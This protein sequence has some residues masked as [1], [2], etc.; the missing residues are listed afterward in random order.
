MQT[1]RSNKTAGEK[2]DLREACVL[3]ALQI[4][5]QNGF[6]TLS[7]R[8][9]ARRLKVSH[10]APYKHFPDRD[11]LVAE[12][13]R[14]A[15]TDFT[16]F[17]DAAT[18]DCAPQDVLPA[19]G[20]A[21]LEYAMQNPLQYRLMFGTPLPDLKAHPALAAQASEA[22]AL[23]KEAVRAMKPDA[24]E[25]RLTQDALFAWSTVHGL[26]SITQFGSFSAVGIRESGEMT[27]AIETTMQHVC[28]LINPP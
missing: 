28:R 10:Q 9:V 21:Y 15:F 7:L 17:L 23:L 12:V 6:E 22:F 14:R 4:I 19:L 5:R 18:G 24:D 20:R 27:E 2:T 8:E 26:A 11:H 3:E 25:K 1:R 13:M 16:R